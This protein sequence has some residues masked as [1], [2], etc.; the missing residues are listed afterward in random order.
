MYFDD[1]ELVMWKY[2]VLVI[3]YNF[4][5][6][7]QLIIVVFFELYVLFGG[8]DVFLISINVFFIIKKMGGEGCRR[9]DKNELEMKRKLY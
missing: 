2:V 5:R 6:L 3:F 4:Q 1:R 7:F 9:S 8:E